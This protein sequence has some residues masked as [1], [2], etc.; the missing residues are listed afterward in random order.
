M[1]IV[2]ERDIKPLSQL[3]SLADSEAVTRLHEWL[4]KLG[5]NRSQAKVYVALLRLH[6]ARG[7]L[8]AKYAS[9]SR[10]EAYRVL[11]NLETMEM[12]ERIIDNPIRFRPTAPADTLTKL[13]EYEKRR[14]AEVQEAQD[15]ILKIYASLESESAEESGRVSLLQGKRVILRELNLMQESKEQ[16]L[17]AA[18]ANDLALLSFYGG[19]AQM[20]L[21]LLRSKRRG[22]T[23]RVICTGNQELSEDTTREYGGLDLR[24]IQ[25]SSEHIMVVDGSKSIVKVD[26]RKALESTFKMFAKQMELVFEALWIHA[27]PIQE[28]WLT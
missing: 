5:L 19:T 6:E 3:T 16:I 24:S 7:E 27:S 21:S 14:L 12:V 22:G 4:I 17:L 13:I 8:V 10:Q 2:S 28:T 9:I 1:M 18:P 15:E 26:Q 25:G 23:V 20:G 11:S